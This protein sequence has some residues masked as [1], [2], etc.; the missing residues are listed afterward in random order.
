MDR[1]QMRGI[2]K[3]FGGIAALRDAA[4][5]A[6]A[7]EVHALMGENGAGK[8]T[9]MKIL[10]GAYDHEGGEIVVDGVALDIQ[11]P[12]DAI[13]K[14]ISVIYQEF[15]LARHLSV[16]ENILIA[17]MGR[18]NLLDSAAMHRRA[19]DLLRDMG[20]SDIDPRQIVGDLPVAYQQVV[21]I[22][23]ALSRD[24]T[25][26]VLDEPT[27]VLTNHETEKLFD[28]V[29]RLRARGVC[30]IYISHRLD[31]IFALCNRV[32]VMKDGATVGTWETGALNHDQLTQ[33]MIGRALSDF[34][35]PRTAEIGAVA[36]EVRGL[37]A[38][39][40]VRDVSF[41][42]RRGEVLGLGGLVG[43]GRTEV[44]RA[45]FGA[46]PRQAGQVL[47]HGKLVKI[48]SPRE[49]VAAGLG[50]MPEDRKQQGVLLNLPIRSN[51][52]MTPLNPF[53][54]IF[55]LL[56]D[57]AERAATEE[58]RRDLRLKAAS[59]DADVGTLSGGNQ[60]KVVLMKWLVSRCDVLLL[61]EPTRGVDVGAKAEIYRVI[62]DLAA[63][64]AAIVLVSS[65]M[66]ELIGMCDRALIMRAGRIVGEVAGNDM[67]EE[68][69]IELA[70]G[71][72]NVH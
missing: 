71:R 6:R 20:F 63:R 34:F 44:L 40:M 2:S 42:V 7:G 50:L 37:M 49:A 68:K 61:D 43:A 8:S 12:H 24:C 5:S 11:G 48:G 27:A 72:E 70:M 9:L 39:P 45:L 16:A 19:G 51:A 1:L 17:E 22:C 69:I 66:L 23:K 41:T 58:M 10:S 57:R 30:I 13:A 62:N 18:T 64:G 36:L 25:I 26:L 21:E 65:E 60:Q 67:T 28:L 4:F 52:V 29:R 59:I 47:L 55:G 53:L 56:N 3:S 31:E 35:P 46:D 32:T 38:G 54:R 14:G 33:L 15:S